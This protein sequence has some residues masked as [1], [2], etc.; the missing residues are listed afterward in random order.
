MPSYRFCRPDDL[1]LLVRAVVECHDVHFPHRPP[2]TL[3]SFRREMKEIDVWPSNSMVAMGGA[4]GREPIAVSIATKRE[5]AV[6]VHRVGVRPDHLRQGHGGHLLT[7]L[8]QKLAVLGPERLLAEA[9]DDLPAAG[10]FL[11]A[12][13]WRREVELVDWERPAPGAGGDDGA[14]APDGLV[15]P[16]TA[17]DLEQAGALDRVP[18][19][20]WQRSRRSLVQTGDRLAGAAIAGPE[21]IEA[22]LLWTTGS[23]DAVDLASALDRAEGPARTGGA[24][25]PVEI[26]G[27]GCRDPEQAPLLLSLLAR[28][29]ARRTGRLLRLPRLAPGEL[30]EPA[31]RRAGF[32]PV[33]H[34][35]RFTTRATPL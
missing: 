23:G 3:E 15:I 28:W 19:V 5:D 35:H 7:S 21:R 1:P 6:L 30:P 14:P 12:L 34:H 8:S 31:L 27:A 32:T 20:A 10:A 22:W 9:P 29:L 16:V 11:A 18:E 17:A 13:G 2:C 24:A 33:R 4:G 26:P 25:E